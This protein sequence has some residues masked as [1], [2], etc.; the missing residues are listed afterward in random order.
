MD[1]RIE[2][3]SP[4]CFKDIILLYEVCFHTKINEEFLNQKLN[5]QAFGA[6]FLGYIAYD[7]NGQP[8]AYYAVYPC[9]LTNGNEKFLAAQSGDTMTHPDH[10]GQGLF[11]LLAEKTYDL[12]KASNV[13]CVFGFPNENSYPGFVRK[14]NWQHV[15]D[16]RS[17]VVRVKSLPWIR[18]QKAFPFLE[19]FHG[20]WC[21][22]VLNLVP[23]GEVFKASTVTNGN[24]GID[25]SQEF[26]NYKSYGN[27]QMIRLG[28]SNV[29]VKT[30]VSFLWIGD[31]SCEQ[32]EEIA[33]TIKKLKRI[34]FFCGL[35]HLRITLSSDVFL[36]SFFKQHGKVMEAKYPVGVLSFDEEMDFAN[37]KFVT[38]DNDTF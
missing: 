12:C 34:T 24:I 19:R 3:I 11:V 18:V 16:M 8:A 1:Y 28:K 17:Y 10:R 27:N 35:T 29:W 4:S 15:D 30:D 13:R 20:F 31:M 21:K 33:R 26:F 2:Q 23:K 7:K 32:G 9:Y 25:H 6:S 5:T 37:C 38:G 36:E 22:F 14:L